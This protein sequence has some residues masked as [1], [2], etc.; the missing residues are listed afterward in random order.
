MCEPVQPWVFCV[1]SPELK[2]GS[3]ISAVQPSARTGGT[4]VAIGLLLFV[5][6]FLWLKYSVSLQ[7]RGQKMIRRV[8]DLPVVENESFFLGLTRWFGAIFI[9]LMGLLCLIFGL[10]GLTTG[11]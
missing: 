1:K 11:R 10:V 5:A 9:G 7:V 6:A 2:E 4:I 3:N 8:V